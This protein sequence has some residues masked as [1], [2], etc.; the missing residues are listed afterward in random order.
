MSMDGS[1]LVGRSP[2]SLR[3][4]SM[5]TSVHT[6]KKQTSL[7]STYF[8]V[9]Q[10]VHTVNDMNWYILCPRMFYETKPAESNNCSYGASGHG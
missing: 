6:A 5:L 9:Q 10:G 3:M 7:R 4:L 2:R 8:S 1:T